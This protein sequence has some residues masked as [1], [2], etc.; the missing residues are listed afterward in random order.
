MDEKLDMQAVI[1]T[2]QQA[3]APQPVSLGGDDLL[4]VPKHREAM[5]LDLSPYGAAPRR[6]KGTVVVFDAA[7]LVSL[8]K[9][10]CTATPDCLTR[11]YVDTGIST[12]QIV[13]VLNDTSFKG[14]AWRDAR[15]ELHL[16]KTAAFEKWTNINGSMMAQVDFAEFIE[17]NI[18]DIAEPSG[19]DMLEIAQYL[20]ATRKG[21]FK[22]ALRLSSGQYEFEN[23]EKIE[24]KVLAGKVAVPEKFTLGIAPFEGCQPFQIPVRF[25]YRLNDGQLRLGIK[26]ERIESLLDVVIGDVLKVFAEA[27][28]T[29]VMGRPE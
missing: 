20:H 21:E 7:S 19:A 12:L 25:R 22:S 17:E 8:V 6:L 13:A 4:F 10:T 15:V 29:V 2:A 9:E 18:T 24:A 1:D 5:V 3:V 27:G 14:P 23:S 26:L 16:R 11:V 28:L